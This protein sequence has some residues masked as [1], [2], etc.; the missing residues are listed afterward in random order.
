MRQINS[1]SIDNI[2]RVHLLWTSYKFI[3]MVILL[4]LI[5]PIVKFSLN[6]AT[7][8]TTR[9]SACVRNWWGMGQ[10]LV[11]DCTEENTNLFPL[12]QLSRQLALT[13]FLVI[14]S[15]RDR[16][17]LFRNSTDTVSATDVVFHFS[18]MEIFALCVS[19]FRSSQNSLEIIFSLIL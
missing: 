11:D 10:K 14:Y 8:N 17:N 15:F 16:I 12:F 2:N 3:K 9:N 4:S 1:L 5:A 13:I 19:N 7:L 18:S 6:F